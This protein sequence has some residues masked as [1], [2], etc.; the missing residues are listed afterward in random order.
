MHSEETRPPQTGDDN[1]VI[2]IRT[3][4]RP[5]KNKL[6]THGAFARPP[7]RE[8]S[9]TPAYSGPYLGSRSSRRQDDSIVNGSLQRS[10]YYSFWVQRMTGKVQTGRMG[11]HG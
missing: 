10:A 1:K 5:Q 9:S 2:Q 6:A 11:R 3:A 4:P 7:C 8:L